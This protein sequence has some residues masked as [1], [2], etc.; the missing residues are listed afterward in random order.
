MKTLIS[1]RIDIADYQKIQNIAKSQN[2]T[3]TDIF[4]ITLKKILETD[5]E[6]KDW[7]TLKVKPRNEEATEKITVRVLP[8]EKMA[9]EK[10]CAFHKETLTSIIRKFIRNNCA[11]QNNISEKHQQEVLSFKSNLI[12]IGTLLNQ[13]ARSIKSKDF[14]PEELNKITISPNDYAKIK[15]RIDEYSMSIIK[16]IKDWKTMYQLK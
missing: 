16:M 5:F 1:I 12:K 11:D 10:Y 4:N 2:A 14:T 15:T 8:S 9:L 13:I 3:T 6:N 7:E